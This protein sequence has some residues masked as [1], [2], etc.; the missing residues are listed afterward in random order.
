VVGQLVDKWCGSVRGT[1][2]RSDGKVGGYNVEYSHR[3]KE[4]GQKV[5]KQAYKM[6]SANH[7][8]MLANLVVLV[9]VKFE[10]FVT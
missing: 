3:H 4:D 8:L 7:F 5:G 10:K 1:Q 2:T 6:L 9:T